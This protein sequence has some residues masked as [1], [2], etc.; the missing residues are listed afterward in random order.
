MIVNVKLNI[1]GAVGAS[2]S[3]WHVHS[4][5]VV[6]GDCDATNG[7]Y[8]PSMTL[9]GELAI[10]SNVKLQQF[11]NEFLATP[12]NGL[13]LFGPNAVVGRSVVI[14]LDGRKMCANILTDNL[15]KSMRADFNGP[16]VFGYI[17]LQQPLEDPTAPT[18]VFASLRSTS[19][20]P[21]MHNWHVHA[22]AVGSDGA[23][24][25][26]SDS[27]FGRCKS[28]GG[29]WDPTNTGGATCDGVTDWSLCEVGDLKGKHGQLQ[30][31]SVEKKYFF[32][33]SN[34]PLTGPN[35]V[36]YRSITVHAAAGAPRLGCGTIAGEWLL[37]VL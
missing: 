11:E 31:S 8:N 36:S 15:F 13:T 10:N 3:N 21:A 16:D 37:V 1:S 7:H 9:A 32:T 33:D 23:A 18:T 12:R 19:T 26:I 5:P 29:H 6:D 34:L 25:N 20:D 24:G 35:A 4:Y 17:V 30:L 2:D 14:H 27:N 22:S 28:T